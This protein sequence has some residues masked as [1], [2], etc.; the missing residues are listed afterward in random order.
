MKAAI[1]SL[2]L[3][4]LAGFAGAAH[5]QEAAATLP[6]TPFTA[7]HEAR[8]DS[9]TDWDAL[10]GDPGAA[11]VAGLTHPGVAALK[12]SD[13]ARAEGLF[14]RSLRFNGNDVSLRL[15]MG[16]TKMELGKWDEA[17]QYLRTPARE[18]R[19]DP[20][21]KGLLGVTY[22][23]LGD[24]TGAHAQRAALVEMAAACQANCARS[25]EISNGIRMIDAAL[26]EVGVQS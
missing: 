1:H 15:Y 22:A 3:V 14:A 24:I 11:S 17:K 20:E 25:S 10:R 23:K 13:F 19:K 4:G 8:V 5:G 16:V 7:S 2:L 26:A 9:S 21:P 18:L 12:A 6:P